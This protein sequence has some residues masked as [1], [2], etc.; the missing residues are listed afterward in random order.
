MNDYATSVPWVIFRLLNQQFAVSIKYVREMV[1]LPKVV[2]VPQTPPHIRG[3]FDLR[4]KVV[5]VLDLRMR[6]GMI[7]LLA[8]VEDIIHLLEAREQDHRNW[9]S[10]LESSVRERREFKLATDSH[11]CAFGKWYDNFKTDNR[12]L[13]GCLNKFAA[14]H[15]NIHSVAVTVKELEAKGDYDSAYAII[16]QTRDGDL[17]EMI[18]LFSEARTLLRDANREIAVCLEL[19]GKIIAA[20]VDAIETVEKMSETNFGALP[21]SICSFNNG[22]IA[23][24]GKRKNGVE[25]V[26]LL[27]IE[28]VIRQEE[29]VINSLVV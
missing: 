16:N 3:V 21:E 27:E 12:M 28:K 22:Y 7:S 6:L 2:P 14:P 1:T 17:A 8:E 23:G 25:L 24:I 5:P 19:N 26:Q 20:T 4:G 29:D 11:K 18:G 15:K 13:A 9:I 10:E